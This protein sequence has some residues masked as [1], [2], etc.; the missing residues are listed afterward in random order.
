MAT[1]A[2]RRAAWIAAAAVAGGALVALASRGEPSGTGLARFEAAGPMLRLPPGRATAVV[3]RAAGRQWR[4]VRAGA[5][6]WAVAD[7]SPPG[8]ADLAVQVEAG[9]RFLHVSAP[10]RV[11]DR[12]EVRGLDLAEMG[13]APPRLAVTVFAADGQPFTVSLGGPNPQGFAQY[14]RVEG[15]EEVLLLNRYTGEAWAKAVAAP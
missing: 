6:G 1:P 7:G 10:Q 9:L 3:V 12:E 15:S 13:L 2:L 4:F 5:A 8:A 11:L 14:A